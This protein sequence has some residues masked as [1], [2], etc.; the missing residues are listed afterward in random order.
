MRIS[1]I[2]SVSY[3]RNDNNQQVSMRSHIF[4]S[5]TDS[6]S[7]KCQASLLDKLAGRIKSEQG[8]HLE[9]LFSQETIQ[10]RVQTLAKQINQDYAGKKVYIICVLNGAKRFAYDL[11]KA[12]G[13]RV[14]GSIKLKS[15]AG[16][17]STGNIK[18]VEQN[19][20]GIENYDHILVIEDIVDT[21]HS[22]NFLLAK[23]AREYKG[24]SVKLCSLLDKPSKR[25]KPVNI[26]YKGFEIEDNFVIGYGL[27]Y[28]GDGRE[29]DAIYQVIRD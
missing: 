18:V 7:F 14:N 17:E 6:V 26:D 24:K 19:F 1:P 25:L 12:M 16:V 5:A 10:A 9:T 8:G 21:G 23:L 29:L 2:G 27:D 4:N 13:K 15:Y 11:T 20:E 28:D 22:M 3:R